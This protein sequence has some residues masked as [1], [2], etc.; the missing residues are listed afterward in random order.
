MIEQ[1]GKPQEQYRGRLI[2]VATQR[3]RF[4]DGTE[5]TFEFAERAPGVRVLVSNG[6]SVLLTKEWRSENQNWDYRLPG[7]KVFD[8]L[9][10]YLSNKEIS[11]SNLQKLACI[12]AQKELQE[13]TSIVLPI[14]LFNQIHHS[15]CGAT[16]IWDLYYFLV[17]TDKL[18]TKL[19]S[20]TTKEGEYTHPQWVSY[21]EAKNFCLTGKIQEDRTV[22]VLLKY[23]LPLV[24]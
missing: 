18:E 9:S 22:A 23:L 16:V 20:I 12:A 17:E 10:E 7:G 24:K 21:Q 19:E 13:E 15:I 8:S 4:L 5:K 14:N 6:K 3:M 11:D 2:R 1:L